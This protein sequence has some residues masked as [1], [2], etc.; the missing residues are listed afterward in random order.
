MTRTLE[1]DQD[2]L[3]QM[4]LE[5]VPDEDL[6]TDD[7]LSQTDGFLLVR[8][9]TLTYLAGDYYFGV[10]YEFWQ[11]RDMYEKGI[12]GEYLD[13]DEEISYCMPLTAAD[14]V[15]ALEQFNKALEE[16]AK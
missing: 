8:I 5:G 15:E 6:Q 4:R 10:H 12:Y 11:D 7:I 3:E 9:S 14:D 1:Q 13:D 16:I 2:L